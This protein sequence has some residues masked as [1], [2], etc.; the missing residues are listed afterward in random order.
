M[1]KFAYLY[2]MPGLKEPQHTEFNTE[3]AYFITVAV[4]LATKEDAVS[5][6]KQLV[7]QNGIHMIELCGGLANADLVAKIKAAVGPKVAV[8]QVMYGPEYRRTLVDY[9]KL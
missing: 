5:A 7:E 8:G 9:L 2:A 3:K 6:A 4:D 1:I